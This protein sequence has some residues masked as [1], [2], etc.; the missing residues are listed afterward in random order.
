MLEKPCIRYFAAGL[1]EQSRHLLFLL[2]PGGL[3]VCIWRLS[4]A[5]AGKCCFAAWVLQHSAYGHQTR[6]LLCASCRLRLLAMPA[7]TELVHAMQT[8][9]QASRH[10]QNSNPKTSPRLHPARPFARQ[11]SSSAKSAHGLTSKAASAGC[12]LC[13]GPGSGQPGVCHG[14]EQLGR[15]GALHC[16]ENLTCT[17]LAVGERLGCTLC[18]D[19]LLANPCKCL[20]SHQPSTPSTWSKPKPASN[21]SGASTGMLCLK[22]T[23][24]LTTNRARGGAGDGSCLVERLAVYC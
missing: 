23:K 14:R 21:P 20:S 11:G 10:V 7:M 9:G 16:P 13:T 18:N 8:D 22:K 19:V 24:I 4:C 2:A 15:S 6:G 1:A 12:A 5:Y 3:R 17:A